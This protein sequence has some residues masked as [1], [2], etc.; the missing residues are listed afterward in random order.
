MKK[1]LLEK[2]SYTVMLLGLVSIVLLFFTVLKGGKLWH[3]DVWLGMAMQ[4]P[5]YGVVTLGLMFCFIC[6]KMD[7]SFMALGNFATI[8]AVR[9]MAANNAEGMS[10]SQVSGVILVG[11]LIALGIAALGGLINGLLVSELDI[12]P[13]MATIAM[14][15]V[16]TGLSVAITRGNTVKGLPALYTEI[17][18]KYLFG[19]LPVPLLIFIIVFLISVFLL[20]HTVFGEKLYMIGTNIKA[21]QFSAINTKRM[22]VCTY[23]LCDVIC[24]IGCLIMISTMAS[25]KA[26]YGSSYV[27]RCILI[28]VLAGVL[29]DG[30]MGKIWNVL[31]S[32]VT[33]QIIAT[34]VNMFPSL[35][36]YYASLIWGALLLVVL[37]LSTK[38][39]GGSLFGLFAKQALPKKGKGAAPAK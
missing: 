19:F 39:N 12:P 32:V 5:E 7:L 16:W 28:L 24:C 13:V 23:M 35:N 33:I 34:G 10:T 20:Q 15:L 11:I 17:G 4:F 36:T 6:G 27:M 1:N 21:S 26:D 25:A 22:V 9:Y 3:G 37:I 8:M 14:Q 29:P 2:N 38:M 30:G 31:I 18:H